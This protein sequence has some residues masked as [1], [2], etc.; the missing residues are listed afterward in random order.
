MTR[1]REIGWIAPILLVLLSAAPLIAQEIPKLSPRKAKGRL[2]P[3]YNR[4]ISGLQRIQIYDIQAQYERQIDDLEAQIEALKEKRD[5]EVESVL[6]A[7][8]KQMLIKIIEQAKERRA[9]GLDDLPLKPASEE[10]PA[11]EATPEE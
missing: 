7:E 6:T 1:C 5:A 9:A 8:Q 2:P 10:A 4:V 3:Y 11:P